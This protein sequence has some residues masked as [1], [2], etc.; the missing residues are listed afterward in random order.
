M[1][2]EYYSWDV[3]AQTCSL[4]AVSSNNLL[5][6]IDN[7]IRPAFEK[8]FLGNLPH[9]PRGITQHI[10]ESKNTHNVTSKSVPSIPVV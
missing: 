6:L 7:G 10:A 1:I 2:T 3:D 4:V 5:P 9:A 8:L